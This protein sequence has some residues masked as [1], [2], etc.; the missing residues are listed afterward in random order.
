MICIGESVVGSFD[1]GSGRISYKGVDAVV[2]V[3]DRI[4]INGKI[5]R[6]PISNI[7]PFLSFFIILTFR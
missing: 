3:S 7:S 6:A 4:S 5:V 2:D 1:E